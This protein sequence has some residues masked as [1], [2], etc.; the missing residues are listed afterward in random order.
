MHGFS[1]IVLDHALKLTEETIPAEQDP[2]APECIAVVR[3]YMAWIA[4]EGSPANYYSELRESVAELSGI[5]LQNNQLPLAAR[6]QDIAR[7]LYEPSQEFQTLGMTQTASWKTAIL[8]L[9]L[10]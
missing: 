8:R 1:R 10:G 3:R 4:E 2:R 7:Q 9:L 6:L 5:A